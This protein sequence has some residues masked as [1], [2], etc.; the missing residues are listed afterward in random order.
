MFRV[1]TVLISPFIFTH[2]NT[3]VDFTGIESFVTV[4]V[5]VGEEDF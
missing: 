4:L 2:N 1:L 3:V 5:T